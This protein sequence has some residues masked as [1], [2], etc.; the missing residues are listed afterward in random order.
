M[1]LRPT[2]PTQPRSLARSTAAALA[3]VFTFAGPLGS[4]IAQEPDTVAADGRT[5]PHYELLGITAVVARPSSTTGGSSAV[6]LELDSISHPPAPSLEQVLRSMPLVQIR[7][8]SRGEAQPALR[9]AEERHVAVLLDGVPLTLGWDH[10][11]D[12]SV[13]PLTAARS[14]TLVRGL[15][16]VLHGPNVLGGVVEVDVARGEERQARPSPATASAAVD[17]TGARSLSVSGGALLETGAGEWVVRAG[18]GYQDRSGLALPGSLG[19][20]EGQRPRFVSDGDELR[21]NTDSKRI[22]GFA[23]AR[24]L[25]RSGRWLSLS[26]S[27]YRVERGVAPEAHVDEPRLWRYPL[28]SR[29]VAAFTGGSGHHPTPFGEGDVEVSVGLDVGKTRIDEFAS[30]SYDVVTG[31]EE[32]DDRTVTLRMLA[33]HTV[34]R[35]GELRAALTYADVRHD[36]LLDPGG[37]AAYRQ[38]LWSLGTEAQWN[39]LD[40]THVSLGVALD[41]ADTPESADKSPLGRLWDWGARVGASSISASGSVLLHGALSRRTRFPALRELY[42]GALG[43]FEPN[44]EL[45]PEV[46]TAAEIGVTYRAGSAEVQLVGF[47]QRLDDG[48]IRV[49]VDTDEGGKLQRVNQDRIRSSGLELLIRGGL[50]TVSLA[51]DLTLQRVRG[52]AGEGEETLLEYRPAWAGKISGEA[53]LPGALAGTATL[54]YRGEQHCENPELGGLQPFDA[55]ASGDVSVRRVFR[56]G[57]G[58]LSRLEA[59]LAVDNVSDS[60]VFDQC[61]LPQPGRTVRVQIRVW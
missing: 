48:I 11:T 20:E 29:L 44:P 19:V 45:Q 13:V 7:Q 27:G 26:A 2:R 49:S 42:S 15:S 12:L 37:P 36:E 53:R 1:L 5:A 6:E 47:H 28:Q 31:G 34:G 60:V 39:V 10:R 54:S 51:G 24:H 61:G 3:L 57:G 25:S 21:L 16:S 23:S 46:M 17:D 8:N 32:S 41:G 43:R 30:E 40:D 35:S 50:R 58:A 22:D 14:I 52:V 56:M 18:A 33:D 4:A 9:G 38:R 55:S 59:L